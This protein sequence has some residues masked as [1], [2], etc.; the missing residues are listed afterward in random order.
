MNLELAYISKAEL[1]N[2]FRTK[3]DCGIVSIDFWTVQ[4]ITQASELLKG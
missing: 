3:C 4:V 1:A 2:K